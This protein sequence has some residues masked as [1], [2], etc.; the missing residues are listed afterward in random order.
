MKEGRN[1][2]TKFGIVVVQTQVYHEKDEDRFLGFIINIF[3]NINSPEF[4]NLNEIKNDRVKR[5]DIVKLARFLVR[6]WSRLQTG[7]V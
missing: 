1:E 6:Y 3:T 2:G 4:S 7:A 5:Q